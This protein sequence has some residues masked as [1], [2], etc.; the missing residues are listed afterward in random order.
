M[1]EFIVLIRIFRDFCFFFVFRLR[2]DGSNNML[3][4][5]VSQSNS[6]TSSNSELDKDIAEL[7]LNGST[8]NGEPVEGDEENGG[9]SSN[10]SVIIINKNST[11][12]K[13]VSSSRTP[14][15]KAKRVRFFRNGDKFYGGVVIPVSNERYRYVEKCPYFQLKSRLN[16]F[17]V[18]FYRSFDSLAEDLT[19]ILEDRVSGAVRN[20]YSTLGKKVSAFETWLMIIY[21]LPV[22]NW[23]RLGNFP[24]FTHRSQV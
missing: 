5:T 9:T 24:R 7:D 20:I 15:R 1:A 8:P 14:T 2:M 6:S 3:E 18:L 12:K 4:T 21:S 10:G 17:L 11:L 16:I 13:R 19:R 23:I 22:H